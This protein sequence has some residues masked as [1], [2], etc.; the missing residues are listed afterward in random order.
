MNGKT[1]SHSGDVA[2]IENFVLSFDQHPF[3]FLPLTDKPGIGHGHQFFVNSNDRGEFSPPILGTCLVLSLPSCLDTLIHV[4]WTTACFLS[5]GPH[6]KAPGHAHSRA[7]KHK[8]W[9]TPLTYL[10]PELGNGEQ[11]GAYTVASLTLGGAPS[12]TALSLV[13]RQR[14]TGHV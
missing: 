12:K 5:S 3:Y 7:R 9:D 11:C 6:L 1:F 10:H 8:G 4:E 2:G 13:C 14:A